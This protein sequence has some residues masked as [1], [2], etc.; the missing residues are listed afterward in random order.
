MTHRLQIYLI[1]KTN[2]PSFCVGSLRSRVSVHSSCKSV[3]LS[4]QCNV[5][6]PE[7][8]NSREL[9]LGNHHP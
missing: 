6:E 1:R 8:S 7:T 9:R 5:D 2:A 4:N 3:H